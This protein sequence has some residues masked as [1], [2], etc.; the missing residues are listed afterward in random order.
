MNVARKTYT[1]AINDALNQIRPQILADV[2]QLNEKL[3]VSKTN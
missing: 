1:D 2:N 3:K